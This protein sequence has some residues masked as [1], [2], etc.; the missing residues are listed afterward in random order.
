MNW[1]YC[2][3]SAIF[4]SPRCKYP[5]SGVALVTISPSS[6]R[7]MRRTPCVDGCEGPMLITSFSPSISSVSCMAFKLR[8]NASGCSSVV[9]AIYSSIVWFSKKTEHR[10]A[11]AFSSAAKSLCV[12]EK[13]QAAYFTAAYFTAAYFTEGSG[14]GFCLLRPAGHLSKPASDGI[15]SALVRVWALE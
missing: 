4:S 11:G 5:M 10:P 8:A 15:V 6:S 2:M 7:I 14:F 3:F 13:M 1:L 9:V 12:W